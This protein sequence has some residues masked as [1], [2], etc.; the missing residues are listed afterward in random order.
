[1]L[2]IGTPPRLSGNFRELCSPVF[3]FII[4][5]RNTNPEKKQSR[6]QTAH[7]NILKMFRIVTCLM[8]H[9]C[10]KFRENPFFHFPV[11]LLTYKLTNNRIWNHNLRRSAEVNIRLQNAGAFI[12]KTPNKFLLGAIHIKPLVSQFPVFGYQRTR[13]SRITT[14]VNRG[15]EMHYISMYQI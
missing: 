14:K 3:F 4:L 11:M 1:M 9:V 2:L 13:K 12:A 6:I 7:R 5:L 10:W 8:S 15:Q